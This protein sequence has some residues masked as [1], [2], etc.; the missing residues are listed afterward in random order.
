MMNER[1]VTTRKLQED[2][3]IAL[4]ECEHD[5]LFV[6]TDEHTAEHCWPVVKDFLCLR[7]AQLITIPAGDEHKTIQT[8]TRVWEQLSESGATRHSC[9]VN[10]GGGMVCDLGGFVASTFKRGINYINLPTTLLAMVDASAGGKTGLN[11]NGLKNEVGTFC[12]PHRVIIHT[13]FLQTLG[14][15]E[16]LSGYAEMLKHGLLDGEDLWAETML[17]PLHPCTL[18]PSNSLSS[19]IE[20]S[21]AVKQRIVEADP[22]EQDLRKVLNLGHTVGHALESYSNNV[23]PTPHLSPLKHGYAV[24]FGLI[25]ELYL[26]AIKCGFPTD[27]LRQTVSFIREHYGTVDIICDDYDTLIALMHHDK[28][29]MSGQINFTLLA[30]VG[31]VRINQTATD[32]EIREAL[33]FLREG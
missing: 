28:K 19:L 17:A 9:L 18:E 25:C 29:N 16:L 3:V 10:L 7:K 6:L 2:L 26:S 8:A 13:P 30:G 27:R 33:D 32:E 24:A 11:L 12:Q 4:S 23:A 14:T 5:G 22:M 15:E 21:I 20:R 31:D 1:I